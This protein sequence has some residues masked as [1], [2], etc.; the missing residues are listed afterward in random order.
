MR[1]LIAKSSGFCRGVQ[2]AVDTAMSAPAENTY[3]LGELIHNP[4][5]LAQIAG[6]GIKTVENVSEVP[7]GATLIFRS[8][9]V[10]QAVYE[11]CGRRGIK[12][13][14]C[15]CSFVKRIQDIVHDLSDTDKTIV[16]VG[17]AAHPE[18]VGLNGWC[19]G[20]A[21]VIDSPESP[22]I[23]SLADKNVAIVSQTTFSEEKFDKII[24]NI[25]KV[26]KK[27]VEIFKTICYTTKERQREA[28]QLAERCDAMIVLGGMNSS[29]TQKLY[30]ICKSRCDRVFRLACAD[31]FQPET[32]K[33]FKNVGIVS[34]ASTP[35]A[36]TQEVL[37][38]MDNNTEVKATNEME[39][40]VAQ[41]DN[42]QSKL[43]R[44]QLVTAIISSATDEGV[45]VLLPFFKKEILLE[46]DEID[47]EE[48]KAEDYASKVGEEIEVMVVSAANPVKLSQKIIKQIKEEEGKIAAIEAGEEFDVTCTG[49]N[50]G[51]L[52]AAMGTYAV[53]VPAKEIRMGYV[54]E[55]DKYVGKKLR[56]KALEIK[57]S[58]RKK[59]IIAS[60]RVILEEEKAA[61]DAAKAEKEAEFFANIHVGDVVEG[62]VER[63]TNFGA[64]VS[65]NGFDCL[66]HISDLS[67]SGVKNVT[68]VLEIGKKYEFK[69]LKIDEE[70]KKVSIGYKQLQPQ[71]WDLVA[72]KYAEGDVV[73][74]KVVRIVPFGAFVEIENGVDG[75]VHVSQISHEWLE[76]PTSVLTIGEEIDAKILVLDPANKKMTLSIKA[77]LPEPEVTKVRTRRDDEKS[78][79]PRNRKPRQARDD[80]EEGEFREWTEGGIG[81]ASIAEMLQNKNDN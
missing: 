35:L 71:P 27:T 1:V 72:E 75:L 32:I 12:V 29:N 5:V 74:G 39:E 52:T 2:H 34:G 58:D 63:V 23:A 46:K 19:G 66:A 13:I 7:D 22:E 4:N 18:V 33:N 3:I 81:G 65:V 50:K 60:Q 67:W 36:Q 42:G 64:F 24:K 38:K 15:T 31:E 44:G 10:G 40:V 16:I 48:Y 70:N 62:K 73:H 76:N 51:G 9:G 43:K 78:D 53:F 79:R 21:V 80:R 37:F 54:K 55:L 47:C 8:H 49:F 28:A 20:R 26:C 25:E 77:L 57:K 14:D 41:M 6:R 30:E 68:D 56:L 69:V 59:E 61:R 45:A 17:N 11:E